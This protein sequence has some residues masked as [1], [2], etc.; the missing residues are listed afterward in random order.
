MTEQN[1]MISDRLYAAL[2]LA[3]KLHGRDA[4]KESRTPV[5]AHLLSVCA[6]VQHETDDEDEAVAALLHDTLEDH[7]DGGRTRRVILEQFGEKVLQIVDISSDTPPGFAGGPKEK[8]KPRKQAYI[9]RI[10]KTDA[11]LLRVTVAD[12][13]DNARAI[14][15]DHLRL[16]DEVWLRFTTQSKKDQQW[17]YTEVLKAYDKAGFNG[18]MLE[19]LRGLVAKINLL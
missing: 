9:D 10:V 4:R 13:V 3:F 6:L 11:S 14:L 8:W 7:P 15:A 19:E 2:E 5:M 17:F 1:K 16:G 12:K 18:G